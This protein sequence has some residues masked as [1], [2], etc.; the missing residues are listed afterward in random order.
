MFINGDLCRLPGIP[1]SLVYLAIFNELNKYVN[2]QTS[3]NTRISWK[4]P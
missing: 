1:D 4:F 3:G 2:G